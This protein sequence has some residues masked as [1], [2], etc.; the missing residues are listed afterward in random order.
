[1]RPFTVYYKMCGTNDVHSMKVVKVTKDQ[2][3]EA[4]GNWNSKDSV[5]FTKRQARKHKC[6]CVSCRAF[7]GMRF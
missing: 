6:S 7:Q 4:D 3:E 5:Y 1:M 2:V